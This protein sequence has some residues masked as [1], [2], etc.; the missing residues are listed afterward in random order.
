MN[1]RIGV[2]LIGAVVI[3]AAAPG[4][5]PLRAAVQPGPAAPFDGSVLFIENVG[6]Y[7]GGLRFYAFGAKDAAWFD[8]N[9]LW[10]SRREAAPAAAEA[11][12]PGSQPARASRF[13]PYDSASVDEPAYTA[14]GRPPARVA[15]VKVSPAGGGRLEPYGDTTMQVNYYRGADPAG[16]RA[17]VPAWQGLRWKDIAP[18]V[19]L[20]VGGAG[21]RLAWRTGCQLGADC[22]GAARVRLRVE[23]AQAIARGNAGLVARTALGDLELPFLQADGASVAPAGDG[24]FEIVASLSS[25]AGDEPAVRSPNAPE[26]SPSALA[27]ST[28]FGGRDYDSVEAIARG[29][30][31]ALYVTGVTGSTD[32]YTPGLG[33]G[34][35]ALASSQPAGRFIGP[36]FVAKFQPGLGAGGRVY[37]TFLGDELFDHTMPMTEVGRDIAVD[38]LG[39][40]YVTGQTASHEFPTTP[41]AY[42]TTLNRGVAGNC[43]VGWVSQPCPDA[44][45]AKLNAS[46][47]LAYSTYLGG[48]QL[49]L[50][51]SEDNHGGDDYGISIAVDQHGRM[52]IGGETD[53]DDFPTTPGAYDRVFSFVD[54]GLN[55]DI[56][57]ALIDPAAQGAAGLLYSTYVGAGF[58]NYLGG[59]AVDCQGHAIAAGGVEGRGEMLPPKIDFPRTPG[60]YPTQSECLSYSCSDAFFFKMNPAGGGSADMLYSTFFGGTSPDFLEYEGAR[61]VVIDGT[62]T[63][64]LAGYSS[65]PDYPTTAGAFMPLKPGGSGKTATISKLAP[66]GNGAA[67]LLYSTYLGGERDSQANAIALDAGGHVYVTGATRSGNLPVT[68]GP[69]QSRLTGIEDAFLARLRLNGGGAADLMYGTYLGGSSYD[70]GNALVVAEPGV[71]YLAGATRSDDF[72]VT[73]GAYDTVFA[74]YSCGNYACPDGFVSRLAAGYFAVSGRLTNAQGQA[75]I[76]MRVSANGKYHVVTDAAGAYLLTGLPAGAY[77]LTAASPLFWAP[78]ARIATVPPDAPNQDFQG[79]RILKQAQPDTAS[80]LRHGDRITYTLRLASSTAAQMRLADAIPTHTAYVSGSLESDLPGVAYDPVIAAVS[81]TVDLAAGQTAAVT[82]AVRVAITPTAG[83]EPAIVNQASLRQGS[84]VEWSNRVARFTRIRSVLVPLVQR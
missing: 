59:I 55:T 49:L 60:A 84:V 30:D 71:V 38:A 73:P 17:G 43:P 65:A 13:A 81:G 82:F 39:N 72:P 10:L 1:R 41:G 4:L 79:G 19:D 26:D 32:L 2:A 6:Q 63:A 57:V 62:G 50:P 75:I 12:W 42:A 9:S 47:T 46:G 36:I 27:A 33:A 11:S 3:A 21:G 34:L 64:Y 40:A 76:G 54:I 14:S 37:L 7:A 68:R 52:L 58:P 61:D 69:F 67:D 20:E 53:S 24:A 23:G 22:A 29:T 5:V 56:F 45:A 51:G 70:Q 25:P 28:F 35:H 83:S 16:W 78:A 18:G 15:L 66:A 8:D 44:F 80:T 74:D 48:S 31:G 77:T